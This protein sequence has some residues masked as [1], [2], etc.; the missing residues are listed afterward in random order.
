MIGFV[1]VG[2]TSVCSCV[3][4]EIDLYTGMCIAVSALFIQCHAQNNYVIILNYDLCTYQKIA[5]VL[6][7][8][9]RG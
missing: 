8:L 9:E 2:A 3:M 1:V 4:F 7:I 6:L 5:W